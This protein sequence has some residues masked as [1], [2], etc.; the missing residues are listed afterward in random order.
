M[1][2]LK[3]SI[4]IVYILLILFAGISCNPV[5]QVL[6]NREYFDKVAKEVVLSGKYCA[7]DTIIKVKSDT[8]YK[9]DTLYET[10]LDTIKLTDKIYIPK[11][12]QRTIVKTIT[13]HDT[14]KSVVVDNAR[15]NTLQGDLTALQEKYINTRKQ[16]Q[17]R[18]NWLIL[19]LIAILVYS[20]RKPII[21]LIKWHFFPM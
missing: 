1:K 21:K 13:I 20:I 3:I 12:S 10:S 9:L 14:I 17:S 19:L 4:F 2:L 8:T 11:I 15:L 6:K 16:A 18:L 7:N 5:K